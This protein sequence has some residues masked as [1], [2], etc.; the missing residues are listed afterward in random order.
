M[1]LNRAISPTIYIQLSQFTYHVDTDFDSL[2]IN[3]LGNLNVK[4]PRVHK[5][6]RSYFECSTVAER[7]K[8]LPTI[9]LSINNPDINHT[10]NEVSIS[11][12]Q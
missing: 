3:K 11:L 2:V 4:M 5:S 10:T 6:K 12:R 7:L 9:R 1:L 8:N